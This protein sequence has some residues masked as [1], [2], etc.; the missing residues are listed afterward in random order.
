MVQAFS[1][2]AAPGEPGAP[3]A[4]AGSVTFMPGAPCVVR[5]AQGTAPKPSM[6]AVVVLEDTGSARVRVPLAGQVVKMA[7]TVRPG[8]WVNHVAAAVSFW[9]LQGCVE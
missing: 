3:G 2:G 1:Q 9:A 4:K 5:G 8:P 7:F 6:A